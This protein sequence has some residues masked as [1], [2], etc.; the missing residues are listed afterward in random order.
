MNATSDRLLPAE[1]SLRALAAELYAGVAGLP[2]VSPHGHVEAR[3]FVDPATRFGSPV[4]LFVLPDHYVTRMLYSQGVPLEALGLGENGE[5]DHR[6][7]WELFCRHFYLFRGTPSGLWLELELEE[8]FG[9]RERIEPG[10]AARL[11]DRLAEMLAGPEFAP[12]ALFERF[13][14]EVLCTTDPAADPLDDH[15]ALRASGWG[16]RVLPTFRPDAV[17][18]LDRAGWREAVRRL[19]QAAGMEIGDY[20]SFVRAL[21]R[22]RESFKAMGAVA[23]DHGVLVP[24]AQELP[25]G[26]AETLFQRALA[27]ES[28]PGDAARFGAHMLME[29]ARMSCEDGLAMQLHPGSWRDHSR[30]VAERFGPDR[31][32]DIPVATEFTRNLLPLLD[33]YGSHPNLTLIVFTL[34]EATYARELAPLAGFY[35]ALKLGPPWWFHDSLNGMRRYFDQVMET[36]GLY[37][38][39]G[40]NDDTR[41]FCSIPAR[42]EV[43]RRAAAGWVAGLVA[44]RI[45]DRR[46]GAEMM[47]ALAV[48]LARTAYK[49][50]SPRTERNPER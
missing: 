15:R 2:I 28:L 11:Y 21:E 12:R 48:G 44:R 39:A 33:R 18:A 9:I 26:E 23:A 22:R 13:R 42:H 50:G 17:L 46:D 35:P 27:G 14:V 4:D 20:R 37:N 1:P 38:T 47:T 43:W 49:L 31:G 8:V 7:I 3:L 10:N 16:G 34:D 5:R 19:G 36:A 30:E 32:G 41:A 6:R 25:P 24:A 40:F 45:I 29:S